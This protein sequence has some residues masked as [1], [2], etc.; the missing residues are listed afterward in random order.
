MSPSSLPAAKA[1]QLDVFQTS[2][3]A[4]SQVCGPAR[5]NGR[6]EMDAEPLKAEVILTDGEVVCC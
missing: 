2:D 5:V 6:N 1:H 4:K 3:D